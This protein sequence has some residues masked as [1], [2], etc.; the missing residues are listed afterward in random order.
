MGVT[1]GPVWITGR[2]TAGTAGAPARCRTGTTRPGSGMIGTTGHLTVHSP[3]RTLRR[4]TRAAGAQRWRRVHGSAGTA[5]CSIRRTATG[6]AR[7]AGSSAGRYA[8]TA[9]PPASRGTAPFT[10]AATGGGTGRGTAASTPTTTAE[11]EAAPTPT[12]TAPA[13]SATA[14]TPT[15]AATTGQGE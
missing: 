12:T 9:E 4:T 14:R 15:A 13:S 7:T 11:R 8:R 1:P 10:G 5:R 2:W 3:A 6:C